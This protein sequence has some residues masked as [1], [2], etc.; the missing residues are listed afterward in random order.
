MTVRSDC[1]AFSHSV[2]VEGDE[3]LPRSL[4][5]PMVRTLALIALRTV[6][7]E[8]SF[9]RRMNETKSERKEAGNS[10][11]VCGSRLTIPH[12]EKTNDIRRNVRS[13][14]AFGHHGDGSPHRRCVSTHAWGEIERRH[15]TACGVPRMEFVLGLRAMDSCGL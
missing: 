11:V 13:M 15:E 9:S 8:I 7:D 6:V 1:I 14:R 2:R 3:R 10:S 12:T 5:R 4:Y